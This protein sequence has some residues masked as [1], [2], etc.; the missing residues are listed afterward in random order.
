MRT[1]EQQTEN[2]A[3]AI[4]YAIFTGML[5]ITSF[6]GYAADTA[7]G[8]ATFGLLLWITALVAGVTLKTPT[9]SQEARRATPKTEG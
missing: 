7:W 4:S 5:L 6:T 3:R 8:V 9:S 1:D 2:T